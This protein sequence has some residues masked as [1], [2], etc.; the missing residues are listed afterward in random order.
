MFQNSWADTKLDD[1]QK[2]HKENTKPALAEFVEEIYFATYSRRSSWKGTAQMEFFKADI[3]D[4]GF[5]LKINLFQEHKS[6][7]SVPQPGHAAW[8]SG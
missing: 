5:L 8:A 2:Y 4:S 1:P 3:S 6:S 7:P